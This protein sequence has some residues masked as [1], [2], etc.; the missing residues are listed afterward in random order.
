MI[1]ANE[2]RVGNRILQAGI[3]YDQAGNP[4]NDASSDE[5]TEVNL[6]VL[7][8]IENNPYNYKPIPITPELFERFG[9][10]Y[11]LDDRQW[12][13]EIQV[14]ALKWYFRFNTEW[15]SE[16]GGIYIDSKIQHLHEL[17]NLFFALTGRE[18]DSTP[19]SP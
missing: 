6:A 1:K 11:S 13:F 10:K 18:I 14:G 4:Y 16:L 15:Y 7:F 3:D 2:L 5:E 17:Q 19:P 9:K 8:D 12:E